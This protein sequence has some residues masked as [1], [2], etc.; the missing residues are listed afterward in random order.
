MIK[1]IKELFSDTKT[2]LLA[3]I[4][5]LMGL[6]LGGTVAYHIIEGWSWADSFYFCVT[7][8][9]TVGYGDLV[10]TTEGSRLFTAFFVLA[11]VAIALAALTIVG[12]SFLAGEEKKIDKRRDNLNLKVPLNKKV[13]E[14]RKEM[15][16]E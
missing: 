14:K 10:P 11:G 15:E 4:S 16:E 12:R 7:T 13:E 3:A 9:T 2:Q 6:I 8:L 1:I 5:A